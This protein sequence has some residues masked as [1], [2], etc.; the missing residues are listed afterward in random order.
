[1]T[2]PIS[3]SENLIS[4]SISQQLFMTPLDSDDENVDSVLKKKTYI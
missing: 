1:M 3:Q 4:M 2:L